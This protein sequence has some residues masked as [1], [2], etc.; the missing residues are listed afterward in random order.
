MKTSFFL[1]TF[2]LIS[3]SAFILYSRFEENSDNTSISISE[4]D[5][6]Y[7]LKASYNANN[8]PRVLQ[9]IN[10]SI[11]PN[12]LSKPEKEYFDI[13]TRRIDVT[14]TLPD[15]TEFYI[16]ESPGKLKIVFDKRKN[17]SS[18]YWRIKAMCEGIKNV[19]AGK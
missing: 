8:T 10:R 14:T 12:D 7:Q 2:C 15:K 5:N 6:T 11:E 9:C 16:K 1:T 18:S 3:L 4:N 17:S 19:L 13:T